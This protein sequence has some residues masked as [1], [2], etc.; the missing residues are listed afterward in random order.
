MTEHAFLPYARQ[1]INQDDTTAVS[2]ALSSPIITRGESVEAFE[3]AIAEYC[4][5]EHAV[6]FNSATSAL[7][8]SCHVAK[9]G[10]SDRIITTPNTFAATTI[11]GMKLQGTP[12]FVDIDLESG[13]FNLE[14]V[15]Q[16]L[17]QH[18]STRG[19]AILMPVHFSGIAVDMKRLEKMVRSPDTV[20]I[21]DAAHAIGSSY[22]DG[23][24]VGSCKWSQMTVFSF[25]AVKTLTTGEGGMVTTNDPE[26]YRHLKHYRDNGIERDPLCWVNAD[27]TTA[28]PGYYE[29][30][31]MTGNYNF[32]SFQAALGLSQLNRLESFIDKRRQLIGHYRHEFQDF[33]G[34]T[35]FQSSQDAYTA[36][37]LAVVQID[38]Q[39]FNTNRAFVMERLREQGIGTQVHYI[40]VYRHPFFTD[41]NIDISAYFPKM[42]QYYSQA[43]TLPLFFDM[44]ADDVKRVVGNLKDILLGERQK[45]RPG[46]GKRRR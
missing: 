22:P 28:Y 10:P 2:E 13:N 36:F 34:I 37:H 4:G 43:L 39:A 30:R 42:E 11:A 1:S 40:P 24:K 31:E 46:R 33:S 5:A 25:H 29:L 45:K 20:I 3:K 17:I 26:L 32:T 12:V 9:V 27:L 38:F 35:M 14:Q 41:H 6:A 19:R 8:A 18:R 7:A 15:E 21:E 16:T 44:A 23:S